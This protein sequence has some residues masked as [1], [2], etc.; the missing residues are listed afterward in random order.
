VY[1]DESRSLGTSGNEREEYPNRYRVVSETY[2]HFLTA[3]V[4]NWLPLFTRP[5]TVNIVLDSWRFLQKDSGFR[6]YGYLILENHP[7]LVA[8]SGGL[9]QNMRRFK[10]SS[11]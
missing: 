2:P 6:I 7:H 4:N 1:N 10:F 5:E 9:R 3:T 11:A 8:A